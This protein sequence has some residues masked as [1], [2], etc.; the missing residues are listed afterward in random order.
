[1]STQSKHLLTEEQYLE[2]KRKADFKSEYYQGEMFA[3]GG[4]GE[5]HILI[6]GNT[7]FALRQQLLGRK[8]RTY[9]NEMRVR[10]TPVGLYHIPTS[11]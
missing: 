9:T 11:S 4:A 7:Y 5:S 8:C 3:L 6:T 10:V 1:M 2:I